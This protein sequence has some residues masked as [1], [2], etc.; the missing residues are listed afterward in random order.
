VRCSSR[1]AKV[2]LQWGLERP[3]QSEQHLEGDP[4]VLLVEAAEYLVAARVHSLCEA[5]GRE[6]KLH[7]SIGALGSEA[8][9]FL[10]GGADLGYDRPMR[11]LVLATVLLASACARETR[12]EQRPGKLVPAQLVACSLDA[13]DAKLRPGAPPV[14]EM[15][16]DFQV[17]AR[18][19]VRDVHIQ[20]GGPYAKLL[21]RH[22]ESCEYEPA[23]KDGRPVATRRAAVYSGY[24]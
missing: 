5:R 9:D 7:R 18:G 8:R 6:T 4:R 15:S 3:R 11:R 2:N 19:R 13:P 23:T 12:P 24:R 14:P 1:D 17:D 21:K 16:A 20:G 22:L 10:S